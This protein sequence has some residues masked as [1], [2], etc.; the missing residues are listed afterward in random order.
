M[1]KKL[2]WRI[3]LPNFFVNFFQQFLPNCV[4]TTCEI[5]GCI[6]LS[7]NQLIRM[8]KSLMFWVAEFRD[9]R[10]F[11]VDHNCTRNKFSSWGMN[12]KCLN[13]IVV[14]VGAT[15]VVDL[16]VWTNFMFKAVQLPACWTQ[17]DTGLANV[18]WNTLSLLE[19]NNFLYW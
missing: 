1:N 17:L 7:R 12:E 14:E 11:K 19:I 6:L 2:N 13:A 4:V 3:Y 10:W 18:N 9:N 15:I 8:K 16:A 5:I